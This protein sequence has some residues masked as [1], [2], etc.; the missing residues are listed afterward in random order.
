MILSDADIDVAGVKG[1]KV[2]DKKWKNKI[3]GAKCAEQH[4]AVGTRKRSEEIHIVS[5]LTDK[6]SLDIWT[7]VPNIA[8]KVAPTA[9]TSDSPELM[10]KDKEWKWQSDMYSRFNEFCTV[11]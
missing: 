6:Y 1:L 8:R 5:V 10:L 7:I 4:Q 2:A 3:T 11:Q 9:S